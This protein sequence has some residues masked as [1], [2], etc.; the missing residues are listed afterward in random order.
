ARRL[1]APRTLGIHGQDLAAVCRTV[2][3]D[4]RA[5]DEAFRGIDAFSP[6]ILRGQNR[7]LFQE[8]VP[9]AHGIYK[10]ALDPAWLRR[11]REPVDRHSDPELPLLNRFGHCHVLGETLQRP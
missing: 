11:I 3:T 9:L 6:K 4:D 8:K 1:D 10:A 2:H 5:R 7:Y